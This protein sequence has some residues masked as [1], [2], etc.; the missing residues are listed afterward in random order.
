MIGLYCAIGALVILL[1]IIALN[2]WI[3]KPSKQKR[4]AMN[5][6]DELDGEQLAKKLYG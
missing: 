1:A 6:P 5:P 4:V 3:K 2:T